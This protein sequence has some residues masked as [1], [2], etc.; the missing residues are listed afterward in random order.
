MKCTIPQ[1]MK[2]DVDGCKSSLM[3]AI[4]L[5]C[6]CGV[7]DFVLQGLQNFQEMLW[8]LANLQQL[9]AYPSWRIVWAGG[10]HEGHLEFDKPFFVQRIG[11]W[12]RQTIICGI[13]YETKTNT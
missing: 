1:T 12:K 7:T 2:E 8:S 5:L 10:V 4:A 13:R 9:D 6:S 3:H 11:I